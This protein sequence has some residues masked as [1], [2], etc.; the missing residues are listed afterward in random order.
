MRVSPVRDPWLLCRRTGAVLAAAALV[1]ACRPREPQ[2]LAVIVSGDTAGWIV[3]CGCA[4]NQSGGLPRRGSCLA[5]TRSEGEPRVLDAG[6]AARGTSPYD[7]L[8][9]EAILEGERRMDVAAHNL[10]AAEAALPAD[11]LRGLMREKQVPFV[12]ANLR[13]ADGRLLAEALRI[14]RRAGRRIGVVGVLSP[15]LVAAGLRA[16]PPRNAVLEALRAAAGQYDAAIVLAYAPADELRE[17]AAALPEA[18]V[19]C[20]GPTGQPLEP[21]AIGPVLL[22]SATNMGKF[23]VRL[24]SRTGGPG[25]TGRIINLD[26]RF[27]DDPAQQA[28]V[29][30]FRAELGRCDFTPEQTGHAPLRVSDP[31]ADYRVAGTESC[32][33]CHAE[34][35]GLWEKSAHARAWQSL[36][37]R[38]AHVDP[39]CQ[40]CHT[41]GYGLPGGFR[42]AGTTPER[43][44]VGCESCHGPAQGHVRDPKVR[45]TCYR[46]AMGLCAGCH[47]P[48]NSPHFAESE[49]WE[50]IRHGRPAQVPPQSSRHTPCAVCLLSPCSGDGTRSVPATF[51]SSR[52]RP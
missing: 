19:V 25:W 5:Q 28:N 40:R 45:T 20:G 36:Q 1:G 2:P 29:E 37:S 6:G 17:L 21:E 24:D 31:P 33:P 43:A 27:A 50:R 51:H 42:S 48:E 15:R 4:A 44:A 14:V 13:Q 23:L 8:K 11:Y 9:F 16:D 52:E 47:D 26:E 34:D 7:R 30:R 3:P 38:Q 41:T 49:Y 10:G 22:A 12:S 32:R 18:D 39:D 35:C 46:Q